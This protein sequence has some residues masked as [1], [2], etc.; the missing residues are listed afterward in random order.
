MDPR[1]PHEIDD[2]E[3]EGVPAAR[4]RVGRV[5]ALLAVAGRATESGELQVCDAESGTP[6]AS[7]VVQDGRLHLV[8]G[9]GDDGAVH[10]LLRRWSPPTLDVLRTAV[11][12]AR[13]GGRPLEAVLADAGGRHLEVVRAALEQVLCRQLLELAGRTLG[14]RLVM[15]FKPL[16]KARGVGLAFSPEALYR[17]VVTHA[18]PAP[19][20][21]AV[22]HYERV[23]DLAEVAM[24]VW[25]DRDAQATPLPLRFQGFEG[26]ALS[27]IA[28]IARSV[29]PLARPPSLVVQG[30][31]PRT[32][33]LAHDG[34]TWLCRVA[35]DTACLTRHAGAQAET[36]LEGQGGP[37]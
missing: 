26:M 8:R 36:L 7:M 34:G 12:A 33:V 24:L 13:T 28:R 30:I 1:E 31:E 11:Y 20:G 22:A 18:L 35:G 14:R 4:R 9:A 19:A 29:G 23:R 27:E 32:M 6:L 2:A 15:P 16:E 37:A 25:V 5:L 21:P 10:D 3:V 17:R